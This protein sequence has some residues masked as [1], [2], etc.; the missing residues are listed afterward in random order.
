LDLANKKQGE[1][2]VPVLISFK[3]NKKL[4][5]IGGYDTSVTIK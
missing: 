3:D 5:A 2:T 4:W 1:H